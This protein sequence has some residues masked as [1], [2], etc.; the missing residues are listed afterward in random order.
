MKVEVT[1]DQQA[2]DDQLRQRS[3]APS[4]VLAGFAG[5]A[6]KD[7]KAEMQR[8]AGGDWWPVT[9]SISNVGQ[10]PTLTISVSATNP[11]VI[12]PKRA[13]RLVFVKDG[14]TIFAMKVNHPGSAP[15]KDVIKDALQ[16]TTAQGSSIAAA[17]T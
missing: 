2:L 17:A 11:H 5:Q 6:T 13:P 16:M 1:L 7:I 9:S 3:G 12:V 15:P 10:N 4:R 14:R 8:R